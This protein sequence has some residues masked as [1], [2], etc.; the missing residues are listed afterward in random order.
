MRIL[1]SDQENVSI[2]LVSATEVVKTVTELT[3]LTKLLSSFNVV[4]KNV[5]EWQE[6][7]QGVQLVTGVVADI[8]KNNKIVLVEIQ[9]AQDP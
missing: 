6:E 3:H 5:E 8:D 4:E 1:T 7:N 9:Q 2:V